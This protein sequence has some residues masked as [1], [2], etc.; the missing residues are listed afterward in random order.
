LPGCFF[1]GFSLQVTKN[2]WSAI[3]DGEKI[4]F[5]IENWPHIIPQILVAR[6]I[7]LMV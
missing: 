3:L 7:G 4:D 6:R 5:L 1:I 2:D